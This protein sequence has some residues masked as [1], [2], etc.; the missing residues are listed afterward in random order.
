MILPALSSLL[1]ALAFASPLATPAP[2]QSDPPKIPIAMNLSSVND[3]T[4][5][6]P[7]RNLMWSAR[8]WH[9]R[10]SDG[11]GPFNTELAGKIPLDE[12]GYPLE[13]PFAPEGEQE[14]VVFT[15]INNLTEPGEYLLL[16]DGEGEIGP[17][18]TT[19][20]LSA[21]PGRVV[22]ELKGGSFG[23]SYEGFAILKSAKGNHIRNIRIVKPEDEKTDLAANPYR[24]DFLEYCRQW[25][26]LRFMD[27]QATNNSLEDEW[28]DRKLPSFYT[29][30][31]SGGDATGR[32]GKPASAF[33]RLFSGGV[34]LELLIQLA[35][36]TKTNPWFCVPH[37]ATPEYMTEMAKMI[38]EKLDPSLTAYIEYSN[39]VWNWQFEQANWMLH[40]KI[41][42]EPLADEK[43]NGWKN[44]TPPTEF[45]FDNGTVAR[46]GGADHPE[47]M[48]VLMRRCFKHFEDV[49]TGDDRKRI[50]RVIGVQQA[51]PDTVRRTA[52]W[53]VNNGG[54]DALAPA[55]YF[56][57][58]KEVYASWETAGESLTA[59][60]V[61][62][63]MHLVLDTQSSRWIAEIA[64]IAREFSLR[65]IV[66]EGG[67]H[68]Q[69]KDQQEK[70]YMPALKEAQ[71]SKGLY[72]CYMKNFRLHAEAGCDLF[73]AFSS[74]SEQGTRWGSWGHQEF[75]G[76]SRDVIPKYG[77][78][79]DA[80]T[81]KK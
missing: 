9:T 54:A 14:Q 27:W 8:A 68:I 78:L 60:Q 45:P 55:G 76:Q 69:P 6:Y 38:K 71:F 39:E 48:A 4:P 53:V 62:A 32:T 1:L 36:Q 75:T 47:R 3:W 12:N 73:A 11:S 65:Y 72:D 52:R 15:I 49:F 79:L 46:D 13:L 10:N 81:P 24:E 41:A 40:T 70:P 34:A 7:F 17:A 43:L 33:R 66:Y 63:D 35:N 20:I 29:M 42:A 22:L 25:H 44:R 21:E 74:F 30:V 57:P 56:G 77:A 37:R 67:Q 31:G 51:W 58:D 64:G 19:R 59:D 2:A 16:Y 26:A 18:M 50:V 80:N 23:A 28:R 5:G 61:I